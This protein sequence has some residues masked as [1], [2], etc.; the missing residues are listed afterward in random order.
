MDP[1]LELLTLANTDHQ[2]DSIHSA[3]CRVVALLQDRSSLARADGHNAVSGRTPS[4]LV[5]IVHRCADLV[6]LRLENLLKRNQHL[7]RGWS[8]KLTRDDRLFRLR[9]TEVCL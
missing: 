7:V 2:W 9:H 4:L 6:R 5:V 3:I 8:W 1:D